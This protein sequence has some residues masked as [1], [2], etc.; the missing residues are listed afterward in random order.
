MVTPENSDGDQTVAKWQGY[1]QVSTDIENIQPIGEFTLLLCFMPQLSLAAAYI[2]SLFQVG[3]DGGTGSSCLLVSLLVAPLFILVCQL[4]Q[5]P[6]TPRKTGPQPNPAKLAG[7][8]CGDQVWTVSVFVTTAG[9][10]QQYLKVQ[11]SHLEPSAGETSRAD[12]QLM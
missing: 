8:A 12:M 3:Q 2:I 9:P 11:A 1:R 4:F 10:A 7:P 6:S 5:S